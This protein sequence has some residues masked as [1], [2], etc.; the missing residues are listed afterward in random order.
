MPKQKKRKLKAERRAWHR[1]WGPAV[2]HRKQP[3]RRGRAS[4][5]SLRIDCAVHPGQ[6]QF[7][8]LHEVQWCKRCYEECPACSKTAMPIPLSPPRRHVTMSRTRAARVQSD[9]VRIR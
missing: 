4:G 8:A 1:W 3:K 2:T 6:V 7:C 5:H 9:L